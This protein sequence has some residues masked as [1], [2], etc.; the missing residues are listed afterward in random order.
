MPG[1]QHDVRDLMNGV[2]HYLG[3][4]VEADPLASTLEFWDADQLADVKRV[5]NSGYRQFLYPPAVDEKSPHEW[6]FLTPAAV[7]VFGAG[8]AS[9]DLPLD[10]SGV[11]FGVVVQG[12]G[13]VA[14]FKHQKLKIIPEHDWLAITGNNATAVLG[15]PKY[16]SIISPTQQGGVEQSYQ[17]ALYPAP[18]NGVTIRYRYM[19]EPLMLDE[20]QVIPWGGD[21]HSETLMQSCLAAAELLQDDE[22]GVHW[23]RFLHRLRFSIAIDERERAATES[24]D[25]NWPIEELEPDEDTLQI[26]YQDLRREC[27]AEA[28]YGRD[29]KAWSHEQFKLV[30][31]CVQNGYRAFLAP[32]VLEGQ[33]GPWDW[34]FNKPVA[35]LEL[36]ANVH[37]YDLPADCGSIVEEFTYQ[38]VLP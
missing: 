8:V 30:E 3:H 7:Q 26:T 32:P 10:C 35:E 29:S 34:S 4:N 2:G 37:K 1:L 6:T 11:V 16:A 19:R 15:T 31:F 25:S 27:G 5:V 9:V 38:G 28:R 14:D 21:R 36:S 18:Q 33:K 23:E 12:T 24:S 13:D 22:H 20:T 17:M